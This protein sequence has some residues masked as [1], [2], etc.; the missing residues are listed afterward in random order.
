MRQQLLLCFWNSIERISGLIIYIIFSDLLYTLNMKAF[1]I[2]MMAAGLAIAGDFSKSCDDITLEDSRY[3]VAECQRKNSS[4]QVSKLDLNA[5]YS[6]NGFSLKAEP[7]L[8]H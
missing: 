3:L 4:S 7:R 1:V 5:C 2:V 8:E 6:N